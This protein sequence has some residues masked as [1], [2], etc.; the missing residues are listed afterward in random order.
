MTAALATAGMSVANRV[1]AAPLLTNIGFRGGLDATDFG[2]EPGDISA[3]AQAFSKMLKAA[4]SR[5]LPVFLPAGTYALSSID[6]PD[7][8]RLEGVPGAT[9]LVYS[10]DGYFMRANGAKRVEF[11]NLILDGANRWLSEDAP[12]LVTI[13]GAGS[14]SIRNCDIL[15]STRFGIWTER[16]GGDIRENRI[17]GAADSAIYAVES[18]GFDISGNTISECGNG[19][20]LVHRWN[21]ATDGSTI[22]NNRISAIRANAG[23][24]GQNGNGI[25]VFRADDVQ[26]SNNHISDCAFT[27]I[28]SNA[29]SNVQITANH[30]T[31]L[32]E[33]AIYSEFGF[34]GAMIANNLIDG[35]ANGISS[36]NFNDGGRLAVINGNIIRNL[37]MTAPY[38]ADDAIFGIGLSAEADA[39]L[40]GNLVEN[41]PRWGMAL[42][43]GPYLR[44]INATGNIIRNTP[45]GC[46]VSVVDGAGAALIRDNLFSGISDTAIS[47]FRWMDKVT[48]DLSRDDTSAYPNLDIGGN[49]LTS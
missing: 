26:V 15:G 43:W 19:G 5:N 8:I 30:C 46:A 4:S 39:V 44:D 49:R 20:I 13:R 10:G 29:G 12:G 32:G 27:A 2:I 11:A 41:A 37:K 7:N 36:V 40:T 33:T 23:G 35:A 3:K 38:V 21:K 16:S 18:S 17:S 14:V 45:I 34:E 1:W 6:L 28:R 48:G 47:G 24:T 9:R 22:T 31:N 42:G 25:N